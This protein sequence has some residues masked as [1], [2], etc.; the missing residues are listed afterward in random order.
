MKENIRSYLEQN[1]RFLK[2]VGPKRA[3]ILRKIAL[4]KVLDLLYFPPRKYVDRR[5]LVRIKDLSQFSGNEKTVYGKVLTKGIKKIR[6]KELLVVI[7]GDA[8]GWL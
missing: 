6:N 8:T 5:S 4:E 1:L 7:I 2:G 3:N